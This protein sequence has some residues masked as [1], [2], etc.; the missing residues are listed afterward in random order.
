M[1][2][3]PAAFSRV[4]LLQGR[5]VGGGVH[6]PKGVPQCLPHSPRTHSQSLAHFPWEQSTDLA[7]HTHSRPLPGAGVP[8][9]PAL[10][11]CTV[12]EGCSMRSATAGILQ[13]V[14]SASPSWLSPSAKWTGASPGMNH[15][16]VIP[17]WLRAQPWG[18]GPSPGAQ[19]AC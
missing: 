1:H 10:P 11:L 7:C 6:T 18:S 16:A 4:G 14:G 3:C 17:D 2:I 12:P 15:L 8:R 9:E 13:A 5:A 19:L